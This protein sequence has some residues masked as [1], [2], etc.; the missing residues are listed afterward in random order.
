MHKKRSN[1]LSAATYAAGDLLTKGA[2]FLLL[3]LYLAYLTPEQI[4]ALAILQSVSLGMAPMF[5]NGISMAVTRFYQDYEPR[6]EQLVATLLVVGL[7]IS[8]IGTGLLI[9]TYY[10]LPL[11]PDT[12]FSPT[13]VVAW[14][15][16][17]LL[18]SNSLILE[19][20]YMIRGEALRYRTLTFI[21]FGVSVATIFPLVILTDLNLLGIAIGEIFAYG[22]TLLYLSSSLLRQHA[23][24]YKMIRARTLW[25][26]SYPLAIHSIFV[27]A[28][29]YS[30]RF[31]LRYYVG[32]DEIGSYHIGYL[33][34]SIVPT[35][36]LAIKNAWLP[37]FFRSA[38]H[39]R[40]S[41]TQFANWLANYYV[42][43]LAFSM[44]AICITQPLAEALLP[45]NYQTSI[46]VTKLVIIAMVFQS[47]MTVLVNPLYYANRTK[48]VA[49][50]TGLSLLTNIIA[51]IAL[52]PLFGISGAAL[53]STLAYGFAAFG[54]YWEASK[55]YVLTAAVGKLVAGTAWF[56]IVATASIIFDTHASLNLLY[57]TALFAV[58]IVVILS[59]PK[60]FLADKNPIQ[61]LSTAYWRRPSNSES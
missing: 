39:D 54:T 48:T 41:G 50:I 24:D 13:I 30:D 40:Q 14:L 1:L 46:T 20:R 38:E 2:K 36:S 51:M 35:I 4:G 31:I 29:S 45:E 27:W 42:F 47:L 37:N 57:G 53:A 49:A 34:A 12:L 22:L 19:R 16:G 9:L 18:R 59:W 32:L 58:F 8:I 3:P 25:H 44:L 5:T 23:P 7:A 26:Y 43:I 56:S 60:H 55:E 11:S 17:G 21:Q 10:L 52:V 6:S 28:L 15:L 61:S 33:L